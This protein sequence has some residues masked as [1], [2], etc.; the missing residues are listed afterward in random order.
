VHQGEQLVTGN[1]D[2]AQA[3]LDRDRVL[4]RDDDHAL[5][6]R[7][8]RR[9]RLVRTGQRGRQPA[10]QLHVVPPVALGRRGDLAGREPERQLVV[11]LDAE[12]PVDRHQVNIGGGLPRDFGEGGQD[13]LP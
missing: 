1:P 5:P 6:R 2:R 3:R 7:P 12:P 13:G 11:Q 4:G 10:R 9:Q 8:D